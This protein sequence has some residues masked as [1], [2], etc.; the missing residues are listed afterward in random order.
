MSFIKPGSFP[1]WSLIFK[2]I[3]APA[4]L[5]RSKG[6][7]ILTFP[8]VLHLRSLDIF[9]TSPPPNL[10]TAVWATLPQ[11]P[12]PSSGA[13][14]GFFSFNWCTLR[15]SLLFSPHPKKKKTEGA[16]RKPPGSFS[17]SYFSFWQLPR[18]QDRHPRACFTSTVLP[19]TPLFL[20]F[21]F[22]RDHGALL[23][24]RRVRCNGTDP[25]NF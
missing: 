7:R 15:N 2:T 19:I 24:H 23:V 16:K 14:R 17:L 11:C 4:G 5:W 21:Y 8:P 3:K 20:G 6:R 1:C 9:T 22:R 12:P 18:P 13:L 10:R 25:R